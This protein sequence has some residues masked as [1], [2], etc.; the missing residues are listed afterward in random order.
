MRLWQDD[1]AFPMQVGLDIGT[2]W[3][4]TVAFNYDGRPYVKI[5]ERAPKPGEKRYKYIS[6][7]EMSF[8]EGCAKNIIGRKRYYEHP[9]GD[10]VVNENYLHI[11]QPA[12]DPYNPKDFV[13]EEKLKVEEIPDTIDEDEVESLDDFLLSQF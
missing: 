6:Y 4:Q 13:V 3:G 2:R 9:E 7:E 11:Q 8:E 10:Y 5:D 12:G 1:W